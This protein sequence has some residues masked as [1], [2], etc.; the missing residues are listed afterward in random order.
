[1]R[2]FI[3]KKVFYFSIAAIAMTTSGCF[4]KKIKEA[5]KTIHAF[6]LNY[7]PGDYRV[8]DTSLVSKAMK[9][10]IVAAA[11]LQAQDAKRLKDLGSTDKPLMIEGD[12]YT[13][14]SEGATMY[15]ILKTTT[16]GDKVRSEV[17]FTN[18]NYNRN[19][20]D[21][22]ILKQESGAWKLDDV[23]YATPQGNAQSTSKLLL[24][25]LNL[26]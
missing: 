13:S 23:L 7:K 25:F 20:I 12:I 2:S 17:S 24:Q 14:L 6:Y 18:V 11:L 19:W 4:I 9:E 26:P 15:Q 10:N 8:V 21:T 3:L 16:E 22:I 1:M 5:E